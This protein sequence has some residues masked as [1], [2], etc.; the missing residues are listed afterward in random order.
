MILTHDNIVQVLDLG[1]AG[2]RYFLALELV[3]GWD[4]GQVLHRSRLVSLPLPQPLGLFVVAEVCRA[5]AHAHA[6]P[7]PD[8]QPMGIVH[9]ALRPNNVLLSAHGEVKLTEFRKA[10]RMRSHEQPPTTVVKGKVEFM[11]PEQ[12]LGMPTDA[13]S[14]LFSLGTLLYLVM[15][16]SGPFEAPSD[17][18]TLMRVQQAQFRPPAEI[19][20][21]LARDVVLI[22]LRAMQRNPEARYQSADDMLVDLEKTSRADFRGIG[23]TELRQ[24]LAELERRDGMPSIGRAQSV[25]EPREGA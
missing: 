10:N 2:G 15:A 13:R 8:G 23:Q 3:D 19:R 25:V 7:A 1:R 22:I 5:L 12:G 18:E 14:D 6:K 24:Y 9:L 20:P 4:L 11:S 17:L 21:D 16:G